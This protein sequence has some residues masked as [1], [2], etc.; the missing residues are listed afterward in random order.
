M[1]AWVSGECNGWGRRGGRQHSCWP[2]GTLQSKYGRRGEVLE[3]SPPRARALRPST[4]RP[5]P[6]SAQALLQQRAH[7]LPLP[8]LRLD[9]A[10]A[11]CQRGGCA[12]AASRPGLQVRLL[13]LLLQQ[14]VLLL[15]GRQQRLF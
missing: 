1:C 8:Q 5:R 13:L 2:V 14:G 7:A 4:H 15:L 10:G 12:G 6:T 3:P 9:G 11:L